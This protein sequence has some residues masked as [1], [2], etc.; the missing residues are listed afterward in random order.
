MKFFI[1]TTNQYKIREIASVLRPLEIPLEVTDPIDPDE[2]EDTFEGNAKIKAIEYAAHVRQV[3]T[4]RI[5]DEY[6]D[7]EMRDAIKYLKMSN[8]WLICEDS[9]IVI[10]ALNNLPGPWSARFNDCKIENG[11]V[12]THTESGCSRD[13]IDRLNNLRVLEMMRDI[14]QPYRAAS[15]IVALMVA[16]INGDIL[17]QTTSELN[18]WVAKELRG[19]KG[20]GYDPIFIAAKS[21][22][23][24]LAEIDL[25]RKNLISHRRKALQQFT[26]WLASQLKK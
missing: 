8:T 14:E 6:P 17:F 15:F 26:I 1:G 19:D 13:E 20:F 24:T 23:K 4:A 7:C 5:L 3:Q 21:F 25:M 10:P 12:I 22:G 9:G 11:K 2:T 16:D 18:G